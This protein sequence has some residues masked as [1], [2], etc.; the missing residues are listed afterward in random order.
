MG[1]FAST[2]LLSQAF[3]SPMNFDQKFK[4]QIDI[5]EL[6]GELVHFFEVELDRDL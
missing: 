5:F 4:I 2:A 3:R 6:L 1:P